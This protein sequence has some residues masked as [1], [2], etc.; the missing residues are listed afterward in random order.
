MRILRR[1]FLY[2]NY[3]KGIYENTSVVICK[4][5]II[6]SNN[7]NAHI[8]CPV[9]LKLT[10]LKLEYWLNFSGHRPFCS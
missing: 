5:V 10:W 9:C 2:E 7:I 8:M 3:D 6:L 4:I 1:C